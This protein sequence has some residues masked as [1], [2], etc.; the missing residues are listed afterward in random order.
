[1]RKILL[2]ITVVLVSC[3]TTVSKRTTE[4]DEIVRQLSESDTVR[5]EPRTYNFTGYKDVLVKAYFDLNGA[6]IIAD[7]MLQ[8]SFN[9]NHFLFLL[10][11]AGTIE[12]GTIRGANGRTESLKNGWFGAIRVLKSGLIENMNFTHCDKWAVYVTGDRKATDDITV[13]TG[14]TFDLTMR[15]GTGY[16]FWNQYGTVSLFNNKFFRCRHAVD[17]GSEGNVTTITNNEF[18]GCFYIPIHQHRYIGDSTGQGMTVAYNKFYDPQYPQIDIGIPFKGKNIVTKNQ[19]IGSRVGIMGRDTIPSGDNIMNGRELKP[20]PVVTSNKTLFQ[21]GGKM[22]LRATGYSTYLWNNGVRGNQ[23]TTTFRLPMVKCF[24]VYGD[25]LTDTA[26]VLAVDTG[27]YFGFYAMSSMGKIEVYS[28]ER[29]VKTL[30]GSQL[31]NYDY[32]L[33]RLPDV[34]LKVHIGNYAYLDNIVRSGGFYDT[35]EEGLKVKLKYMGT[36]S[37]SRPYVNQL[38]G[39]RPL[40]IKVSSGWVEVR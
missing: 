24:T 39:F 8:T 26:T 12:N 38:D 32:Y 30:Q 27:A 18:R 31:H 19:F 4:I 16:G 37:V 25:G 34:W 3:N 1:M 17:C 28:G 2:F 20:A 15:D 7:S 35:F 29:L 22:T 10:D 5:L 23:T 14:C 13:I 9:D 36:A 33:F 11:S 6:T 21:V 40:M